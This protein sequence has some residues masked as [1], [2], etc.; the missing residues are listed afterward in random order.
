M[1]KRCNGAPMQWLLGV[2]LSAI[3]LG[4]LLA[5]LLP[6]CTFLLGALLVGI[7]VWLIQKNR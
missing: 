3:G 4:I 2:I 7:G 1:R 6:K 5:C